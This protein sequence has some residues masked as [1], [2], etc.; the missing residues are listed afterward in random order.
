LDRHFL[1]QF[2]NAQAAFEQ[3]Y[4]STGAY[5]VG[6]SEIASTFDNGN[7][8]TDPKEADDYVI[9]WNSTTS[10]YCVCAKLESSSGNADMSTL[11]SCN[12]NEGGEYYCIQ[13]KQ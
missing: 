8:P 13:N 2:G 3:H 12:W 9:T 7:T 11:T 1:R 6:D 4:A 5:P 10:E